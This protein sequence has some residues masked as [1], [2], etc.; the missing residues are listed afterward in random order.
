MESVDSFDELQKEY[1]DQKDERVVSAHLVN[2]HVYIVPNDLWREHLQSALNQSIND[3]VSVGFV[4]VLPQ[5]TLLDLRAELG[6][7]LGSESMP[8]TFVYLNCVGRCFTKIRPKQEKVMKVKNFLPPQANVPEI[9]ILEINPDTS[10]FTPSIGT[11]TRSSSCSSPSP[12]HVIHGYH[13]S[14][15]SELSGSSK[16]PKLPTIYG[17]NKHNHN[18]NNNRYNN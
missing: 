12:K 18:A 4:R 2:L 5:M 3:T 15:I 9:F 8:K 6:S 16:S 11:T 7:Q 1:L 17:G 13:T 10:P 14:R